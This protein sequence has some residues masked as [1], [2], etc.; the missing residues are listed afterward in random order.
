MGRNI[1]TFTY[2]DEWLE[3][4]NR[5]PLSLSMPLTPGNQPYSGDIVT[6][7]FDNLLPDSEPIRRRLAQR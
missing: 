1:S 4:E 7:Y 3:D 6:N 2:F 5:G